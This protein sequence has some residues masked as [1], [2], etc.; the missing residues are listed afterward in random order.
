MSDQRPADAARQNDEEQ[1]KLTL[2]DSTR[3]NQTEE[4]R[5]KTGEQNDPM[6]AQR[7]GVQSWNSRPFGQLS[8]PELP[9]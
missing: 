6:L 3:R 2:A 1:Q 8:E 5:H 7:E 4:R 9:H